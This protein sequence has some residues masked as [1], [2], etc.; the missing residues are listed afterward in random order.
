[1]GDIVRNAG[2][3]TT[4]QGEFEFL[5]LDLW[6][7]GIHGFRDAQ[8]TITLVLSQTDDAEKPLP[9]GAEYMMGRA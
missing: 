6:T 9:S 3:K 8:R 7:G 2:R 5:S 4:G 1:M